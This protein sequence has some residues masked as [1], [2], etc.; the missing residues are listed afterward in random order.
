MPA[1]C[2]I[3]PLMQCFAISLGVVPN[4]LIA[5]DS[6]ELTNEI[7]SV[8]NGAEDDIRI[9]SNGADV[10]PLCKVWT[11]D[12]AIL[13]LQIGSM[14]GVAI[15]LELRLEESGGRLPRIPALITLDRR[16]D[17]FIA[18]RSQADG[19]VI[20]PLDPI[21]L[22]KAI[23]AVIGGERYEDASYAPTT[24]ATTS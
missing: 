16:A 3:C 7:T 21:R 14:G 12:I 24:V 19:W 5:T 23:R 6:P 2:V 13:D 8:L 9:V 4:V 11:P 22:R 18:R 10:L 1:A 17:V 20:K 15:C